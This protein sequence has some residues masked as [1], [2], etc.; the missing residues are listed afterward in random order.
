MRE[1]L[2]SW[3]VLEVNRITTEGKSKEAETQ[4]DVRE[5]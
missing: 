5:R 2:G 4:S 3:L 1:T